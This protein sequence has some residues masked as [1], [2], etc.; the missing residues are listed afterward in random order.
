MGLPRDRREGL[1]GTGLWRLWLAPEMLGVTCR[2]CFAEVVAW[3]GKEACSRSLCSEV[4]YADR[5]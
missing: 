3:R 4:E 1:Y 5:L 2:L